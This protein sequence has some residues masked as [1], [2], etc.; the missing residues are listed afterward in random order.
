MRAYRLVGSAAVLGGLVAASMTASAPPPGPGV[1]T[2]YLDPTV[3][4]AA[5]PARPAQPGPVGARLAPT[6]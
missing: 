6:D 1:P 4:G 3:V 5:Q 2:S